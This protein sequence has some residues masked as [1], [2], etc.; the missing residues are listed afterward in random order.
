MIVETEIGDSLE[1]I[2]MYVVKQCARSVQCLVACV[3]LYLQLHPLRV[4]LLEVVGFLETAVTSLC[5]TIWNNSYWVLNI[6][7]ITF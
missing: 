4:R 7:S 3:V 6:V 5:V 1:S 2:C